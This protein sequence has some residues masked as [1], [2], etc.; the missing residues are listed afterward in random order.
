M[1]NVK[2]AFLF[3]SVNSF[4]FRY[5]CRIE[6][7]LRCKSLENSR[8]SKFQLEKEKKEMKRIVVIGK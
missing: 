3:T 8:C 7:G 4:L 6:A 1:S 2:T 5:T